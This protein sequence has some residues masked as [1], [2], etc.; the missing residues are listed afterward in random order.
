MNVK[1]V[2]RIIAHVVLIESAFMLIP[3]LIALIDREPQVA[4]SFV[5]TIAIM[6][7]LGV[8]TFLLTKEHSN[9]FY[10]Q[11]SFVATGL[12]WIIMSVFGCL[13]FVFSGQIPNFVDAF[14]E[15]T[16]GFTTT[17]ASIL[18]NVEA[19]SRGLLYW[20][21]FSHWLGGMGVLV[22]LMALI[23]A[24][25]KG[26]SSDL[27]LLQ[28]ESPGPTVEKFTPRIR[29]T[30]LTLYLIYIAMTVL[31]LIC[32]LI[33]G[34]PFFDSVCITF[35]TAG[36]GGFGTLNDSMASYSPAAQ[37]IV[38][39]FMFL[40]GVNF[41]TYYLILT[42]KFK[43]AFRSTEV[44]V[45][46]AIFAFSAI[47]IAINTLSYWGGFGESL[48]HAAFQVS[49]IMTTTGYAT[50]DFNLWPAYSRSLL[51]I[52]MCIGA[53]AGSTGGGMKVSRVVLLCKSLVRN[54]KLSIHPNRAT[55]VQLDSKTVSEKTLD[56]LGAYLIAYVSIIVFS[57]LAISVDNMSTTTNFTAVLACFNNIGPGFDTVGPTGNYADFSAFSKLV[58][59]FDMLLGR[60]EIFPLL[61]LF[62][63]TAWDRSR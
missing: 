51:M 10:T 11:E 54:L 55:S 60:L 50:T 6:I 35:G 59:S 12:S 58:L 46:F 61:A 14:F 16:S 23:P 41:N 18:R 56:N 43:S 42:K 2:G 49:S 4:L 8:G 36:T 1:L 9:S 62:S 44:I 57:F 5:Y 32:L 24:S 47:T 45:Y 30:A 27:Y 19:L 53:C 63:K 26:K 25:K 21:S 7:P 3:I 38:T 40:F 29:Q 39:I 22:F 28:A 31:C 52:L 33:S 20:R 17:G 13:P 48:R 15:I 37:V 34:M